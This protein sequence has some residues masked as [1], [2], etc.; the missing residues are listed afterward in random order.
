[1]NTANMLTDCPRCGKR[2]FREYQDGR[3]CDYCGCSVEIDTTY[4][5]LADELGRALEG[6]MLLV[7][8]N[9]VRPELYQEYHYAM[10]MYR[11]WQAAQGQKGVGG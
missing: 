5:A 1:M 7:E 3:Q 2:M 9:T 10:G 4:K 11:K 8:R 6:L